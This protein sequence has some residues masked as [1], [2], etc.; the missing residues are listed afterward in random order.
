MAKGGFRG[1]PRGPFPPPPA[2][3][4]GIFFHYG[5]CVHLTNTGHET[6]Q[7]PFTEDVNSRQRIF[8]SLFLT[9][10][11]ENFPTFEKADWARLYKHD[12]VEKKANSSFPFTAVGRRVWFSL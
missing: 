8:L 5:S 2:L 10:I 12:G 1:W 4:S 11:P 6:L 9:C 7:S 3:L